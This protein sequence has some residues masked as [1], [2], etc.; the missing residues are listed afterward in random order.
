MGAAIGAVFGLVYVWV[1]AGELPS[2]M[3]LI[4][5]ALGVAA[6]A[7]LVVMLVVRRNDAAGSGDRP[8]RTVFGRRYCTVVILEVIALFGGLRVITGPLDAP[9]ASVAW[10]SVVVGVHFVALAAVWDNP[11][12]HW[13]GVAITLCGAIGLVL[14]IAGAPRA[15]I[16]V[17][18]GVVP[19]AILLGTGWWFALGRGDP[20]PGRSGTS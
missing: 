13:L 15:S 18:S 5:R 10:V 9:E 8:D 6:F 12:V 7:G 17:L 3:S 19:G 1:N 14:A 16:A 2:G 11:F 4:L 20:T